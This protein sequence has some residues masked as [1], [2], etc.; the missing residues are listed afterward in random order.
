[1]EA[2]KLIRNIVFQRE[3]RNS[4]TDFR[5]LYLRADILQNYDFSKRLSLTASK[6]QS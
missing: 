4:D 6:R 1:M 3:S 2:R 5:T